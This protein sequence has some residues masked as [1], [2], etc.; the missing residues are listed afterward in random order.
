M[1]YD[2]IRSTVAG[3]MDWTEDKVRELATKFKNKDVAFIKDVEIINIAKEQRTKSEWLLFKQNIKDKELRIIFQMGMTLRRLD[4]QK[5]QLEIEDL[6]R[7]IIEKYDTKGLHMAQIV[8]NGVFNKYVGNILDKSP[9]PE[10]LKHEIEDLFRNIETRNVFVRAGDNVDTRVR[11]ITTKVFASSPK[12]FIISSKGS[13][14]IECSKII[15]E[16]MKIL[17]SYKIYIYSSEDDKIYFLN[18]KDDKI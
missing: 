1:S 5:M 2:P 7:K 6:K 11:E 17:T 15:S 3:F 18:K 8:Q 12:T 9:T 13:A 14:N 16:V 4:E 10:R